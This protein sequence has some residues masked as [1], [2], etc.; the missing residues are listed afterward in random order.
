MDSE[1]FA[2]R[3]TGLAAL[4]DPIRRELYLFVAAQPDPG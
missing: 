1:D 4:A 3:V 2:E